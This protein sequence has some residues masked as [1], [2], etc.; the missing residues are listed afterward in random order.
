MDPR[1]FRP[2]EVELLI[3]DPAK[4]REKLGWE[5]TTTL[6]EMVAEMVISDLDIVQREANRK[7]R[8]G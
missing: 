3:G 7:D 8:H 1:Y 4:A 6:A 2:T 5:A